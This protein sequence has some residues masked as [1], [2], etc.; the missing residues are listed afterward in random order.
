[1]KIL[2]WADRVVLENVRFLAAYR[3]PGVVPEAEIERAW[4]SV[5]D[6]DRLGVAEPRLAA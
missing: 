6:G 3:R 4:E 5:Q 2:V 1:M